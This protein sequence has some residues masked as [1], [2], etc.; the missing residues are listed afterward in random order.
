MNKTGT[1][2]SIYSLTQISSFWK[3][4]PALRFFLS[5]VMGSFNFQDA[6]STPP[7]SQWKLHKSKLWLNESIRIH[8]WYFNVFFNIFNVSQ[9]IST[10]F[11]DLII[12]DQRIYGNL[13]VHPRAGQLPGPAK[14]DCHSC[15]RVCRRSWRSAR[16]QSPPK[17]LSPYEGFL[18]WGLPQIISN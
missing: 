3:C 15:W 17:S 18:E 7:I 8:Q 2:C 14:K 16:R 9:L 1:S 5:L 4:W 13:H 10:Y 12:S 11:C 6:K